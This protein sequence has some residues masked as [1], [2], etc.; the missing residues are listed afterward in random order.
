MTTKTA[1]LYA[2]VSGERG[3]TGWSHLEPQLACLR[4][5]ALQHG[6]RTA[7]E[8]VSEDTD[9]NEARKGQAQWM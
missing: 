1:I 4:E 7:Q 8:Q 9:A 6:L 3:T 2:R 5:Y